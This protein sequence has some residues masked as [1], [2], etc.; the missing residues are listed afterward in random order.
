MVRRLTHRGPD[1]EGFHVAPG[2]GLG[3]R[4][5]SI[6]DLETGAQPIS[7]EDGSVT[8]VCNGEIYNAPELRNELSAM[9]HR[10]RSRSDIEV[11]VH[12]YEEYGVQCLER[13]RGMFGFALWDASRRR[14]MLGRDRLG[15]KPMFYAVG[16]GEFFFG[17]EL[18]AILA[19]SHLER[20]LDVHALKDL[21]MLGFVLS[22]KT[23]FRRIRRL[24]P[25]HYLLYQEGALSVHRYWNLR[26]P[27][28]DDHQP[29]WNQLQWAQALR[30]KLAESISVHLRSDVPVGA[31]L[32]GGIDS[33][34]IV[35]LM[36][37]Q[38]SRSVSTFSLAYEDPAYDEVT[39]ARTLKDFAR[40]DLAYQEVRFGARDFEL[41]PEAVWHCED[42]FGFGV[43]MARMR[44]SQATSRH[45]K[46]VLTGEGSDEIFGGYSWFRADRFLRPLTAYCGSVCSFVGRRRWM[47]RRWPQASR[48]LRAPA[49]MTLARYK[50]VIDS[51][52]AEFHP[53]LFSEDLTQA[54]S[55]E[56]EPDDQG[57]LPDD[58]SRWDPFA[59][60]QFLEMTIRLPDYVTRHL[61]SVSMA[62]GLEAR[63]PFLDHELVEFCA[64]I[65]PALKMRW[66]T[67][68]YI[69]RK[70]LRQDLPREIVG[71]RK[72]GMAAPYGQWMRALPSFAMEMLTER[73]LREKGYFSFPMVSRMLSEH[74]EGT[75]NHARSLMGILGVQLWDDL[76]VRGC[77]PSWCNPREKP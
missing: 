7:S 48:T 70:A 29:M 49:P 31:W 67:E 72:R 20:T 30:D 76:F 16:G 60:L 2:I 12:L 11:I 38:A 45:V 74:R 23:L 54:L 77:R 14:L 71:R 36:C 9:G 52:T 64:R 53:D 13:L 1:G 6:I 21:L 68:K 41:L 15:I 25:G 46:V 26:F 59:Q 24:E 33:S 75:A 27:A 19:G 22:P 28:M 43:E 8:V 18:K 42:P 37:E 56:I 51:G 61:D 10:F 66:G 40:Y 65:P 32:S 47:S 39:H 63:V 58:F 4:R 44:L 34:G 5:L 50:R 62:Y 73:R 69:L 17:S 57:S 55:A 3:I 35:S